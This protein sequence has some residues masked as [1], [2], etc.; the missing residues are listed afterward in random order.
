MCGIFG[1]VSCTKHSA[2]VVL[3]GLKSLEYRGYDSWGVAV[4]GSHQIQVKKK[5]GKIGQETVTSLPDSHLALGHT[6]WAT[7][8]GVT[9]ENSHPHLDCSHTI[10]VIHN[11]VFQNY[12]SIKQQLIQTGHI[13]HSQTDSEV[14]AHLIEEFATKKPFN[15]AVKEAFLTM[16]GLNAIVA[17][18]TSDRHFIAV[19]S[20]SPLVIGFGEN[21]NFIA[22]D[23]AALLPYTKTVYFVNEN[24]LVIGESD[25]VV[26]SD[27]HTGNR[28]EPKKQVLTWD[29]E[30]AK[31]GEYQHYMLKEIY[32]QLPLLPLI[33]KHGLAKV[34]DIAKRIKKADQVFLTGCGSAGYAAL[35]GD[36]LFRT[37]SFILPHTVVG[38]EFTNELPFITRNSVV[39]AFSQSGETM[40]ILNPM[41]RV[42][43]K[44]AFLISF[45]NVVGSSLY[46]LADKNILMEVGPEKAVASTK[47][48][49]AKLAYLFLLSYELS[50]KPEEGIRLI[51]KASRSIHK[52]L[53]VRCISQ[54]RM[55]A[56]TLKDAQHLYV[57]GRGISYPASLE[58]ALKIKELSYIHAEGMS[59][60][61]LK[62][63]TLALIEKGTPVLVIAPDDGTYDATIAGATEMKARGAWVMGVS[64]KESTVFDDYIPLADAGKATILPAIVVAQLLSYYLAVE[65]GFDPDMPRNL[66]KSVTVV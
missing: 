2:S 26:V 30:Q 4:A 66:A 38:S 7:H 9:D 42:K 3:D 16:Q 33:S 39:L 19:R 18:R 61:E 17:M 11:G 50:G 60:G 54:I 32:E 63:G 55:L 20:G 10:A 21:E 27:I 1:Y 58:A 37:E 35:I 53:R 29:I 65:R 31:K 14:I 49:L 28:I 48:F 41:K 45:V 5:A 15:Q 6:R 23:P 25:Q 12:E 13:F 57:I 62:H 24:E 22:S 40:D 59:A 8:G 51:H 64:S 47:D 52:V 56:K 44:G 34:K 36:Y 43:E 46:R